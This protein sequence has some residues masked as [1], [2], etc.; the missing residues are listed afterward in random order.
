MKYGLLTGAGGGLGMACVQALV[1][2]DWT[3]FAADVNVDRLA[4]L[5]PAAPVIA[6][7]LDVTDP[8]SLDR[9][10][11][12][13]KRTTDRLDAVVNLAGLHAM[14]S[15]VEGDVVATL[16]RM[17]DVNVLGLVGVNRAF[18]ELLLAGGGRIVNCS[19]ECGYMKAQPFNGLYAITKYAVEAYNDALRR[20]LLGLNIPVVKLQPGSFRTNL[21]TAAQSSFDQLSAGTRYHRRALTRMKP[22]M[23]RE[24]RRANDPV[25]LARAVL[26]AVSSRRPRLTYRVRNSRLLG[27]ME[28]VPDRLLDAVYRVLMR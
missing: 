18:F 3:V 5:D 14:G 16:R 21:L 28:L 19:S 22:L 17:I 10:V 7:P 9:A 15:L 27:L 8:T 12:L 20:E 11:E 2:A 4:E 23:T 26:T 6:L 1:A 25:H 13:V 24:F